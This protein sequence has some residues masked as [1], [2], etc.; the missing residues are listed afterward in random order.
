MADTV[1]TR[2]QFEDLMYSV[3]QPMLQSSAEARISWPT[4]GAPTFG[5][6][7]N[8]VFLRCVVDVDDE[9]SLA[10]EYKYEDT[11]P[12]G[13]TRQVGYTRPWKVSGLSYGPDGFDIATEILEKIQ[14]QEYHDILASNRVFHIPAR[15]M[16]NRIPELWAG[17][18]WERA[19]FTM[20]FYE[21]VKRTTEAPYVV[22]VDVTIKTETKTIDQNIS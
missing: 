13:L 21:E 12:V 10:R 4:G 22:S 7:E 14:F 8:K 17:Q 15:A 18:W 20:M 1:L 11:S 2:Q 5:I 19:D 9:Y 6:G 3:I 16:P